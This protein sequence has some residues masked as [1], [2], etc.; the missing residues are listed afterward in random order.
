ML[1]LKAGFWLMIPGFGNLKC[2]NESHRQKESRRERD[3]F[4]GRGAG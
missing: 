4:R 2:K 3:E 1:P